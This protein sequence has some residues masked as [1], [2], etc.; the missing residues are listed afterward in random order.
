[1]LK[2][3]GFVVLSLLAAGTPVDLG[4]LKADA[5]KSWKESAVANSMRVKQFAVPGKDGEAEVIIFYFQGQGGD[6]DQNIKRWKGMFEPPAGKTIDEVSK[7]ET[8]KLPHTK[9]T[10]LDVRGTY[11][12]KARPMDPGPGEKR[13]NQRMLAVFFET[14]KGPYYIRFVGPEKT[15]SQNKKDFD[16]WLKSFK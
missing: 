15:V 1:V 7:V 10:M 12:H 4:G 14:P 3:F 2:P 9:A 11:L 13:P 5:P 6:V 16:G 8:L